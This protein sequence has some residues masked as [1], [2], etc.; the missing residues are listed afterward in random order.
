MCFD[1]LKATEQVCID[2]SALQN[3]EID[4][5][6]L[7]RFDGKV[8]TQTVYRHHG[9]KRHVL[10]PKQPPNTAETGHTSD[11]VI[12]ECPNLTPAGVGRTFFNKDCRYAA[13]V[14]EICLDK[15]ENS[16]F[17]KLCLFIR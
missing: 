9:L 12:A 8:L 14:C 13:S 15:P 17:Y 1:I 11:E 7:Q 16:Q 10:P 6:D 5:H 3:N 4:P 2:S